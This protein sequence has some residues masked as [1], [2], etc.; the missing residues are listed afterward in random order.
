MKNLAVVNDSSERS[1]KL[2]QETVK[3]AYSDKKLQKMLLVKSKMA[4]PTSRTKASYREAASQLTPQQQLDLTFAVNQ[5][6][7]DAE[8]E[9]SS[10]SELDSSIDIVD[11]DDVIDALAVEAIEN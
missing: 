1:V 11:D 10:C 5:V 9:V 4:K 3:Q 8:Q 2:V 7:E 6:E